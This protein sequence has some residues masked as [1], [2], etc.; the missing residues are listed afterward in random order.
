[1][2]VQNVL[3][4]TGKDNLARLHSD[5]KKIRK[6]D[7]DWSPDQL[8]AL[9]GTV[10]FLLSDEKFLS[11]IGPAGSGKTTLMREIVAEAKR[12]RWRINLSA[13]TH[14][15]ARQLANSAKRGAQTIHKVLGLKIKQNN[16][17]GKLDLQSTGETLLE[18]NAFLI[19]DESSMLGVELLEIIR[20]EAETLDCKVLFVG[21][22]A[23]LNPV[24]EEPCVAVD[25]E[26]C[27]W[28]LFE[29]T[30]I[31]RQAA[32]NPIIAAATKIRTSDSGELPKLKTQKK[33]DS[34]VV[35]VDHPKD[36][37]SMMIEACKVDDTE[38]R[39]IGYTNAAVDSAAKH[40]RFAKY[41]QDSINPY[42][43]GEQLIVNERYEFR[44]RYRKK[45][46]SD[47]TKKHAVENNTEITVDR[48]WQ[49]G[50]FYTVCADVD[51]VMIQ[52]K[53]FGSYQERQRYLSQLANV[54]R[55][56]K[57][58]KPFWDANNTIADLRSAVSTTVHKSQ[59]STFRDV[60]VNLGQLGICSDVDELQRL[61][62]V[63]VTRASRCVYLTGAL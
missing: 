61:L 27:P 51:G 49:D 53:A 42:L 33:D 31:H 22:I 9:Q 23:Q 36:W 15:A 19:V 60:Y 12:R 2:S 28:Q 11:I 39:Y 52:F 44:E 37:A 17:T 58:W 47:S 43:K 56:N 21:D 40:I 29:L 5:G 45:D 59:G 48:V 62:Y 10:D 4:F 1:M 24:K 35:F 26:Q 6:S 18:N 32:E 41:G 46:G 54:C 8:E 3:Q 34:G 55:A 50:K 57:K 16:R 20:T 38:D 30:T 14:K 13:P 63:A 25:R 7:I